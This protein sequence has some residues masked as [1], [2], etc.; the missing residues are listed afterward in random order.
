MSSSR[1]VCRATMLGRVLMGWLILVLLI[2]PSFPFGVR[3]GEG[4]VN[5]HVGS[6]DGNLK[7]LGFG[8]FVCD[9][10]APDAFLVGDKRLAPHLT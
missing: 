9:E 1:L 6:V 4:Y 10:F 8:D 5:T 2:M 7:D 3:V